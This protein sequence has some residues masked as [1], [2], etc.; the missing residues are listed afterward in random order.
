MLLIDTGKSVNLVEC[1]FIDNQSQENLV[2]GT[3]SGIL[4]GIFKN[5][6]L[7]KE[8]FTILFIYGPMRLEH[9]VFEGNAA[10]DS[11]FQAYWSDYYLA[12]I[13]FTFLI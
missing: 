4:F 13:R 9:T 2:L 1:S 7:L 12:Q 11:S 3:I 10:M 8:F 5:N 6:R